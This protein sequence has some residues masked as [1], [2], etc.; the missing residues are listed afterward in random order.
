MQAGGLVDD[1]VASV[2]QQ[3]ATDA[4]CKPVNFSFSCVG[5]CGFPSGGDQVKAALAA[6]ANAVTRLCDMFDAA[7]CVLIAPGCGPVSFAGCQQGKCVW[8]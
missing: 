1:A 4:D 8:K 7:G 2:E 5:G 3:C 6:T